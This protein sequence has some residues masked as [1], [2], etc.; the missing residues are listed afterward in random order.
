MLYRLVRNGAGEGTAV[1]AVELFGGE[2][3]DEVLEEGGLRGVLGLN[4]RWV[5][6][7]E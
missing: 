2:D 4:V 1:G 3:N 6:C 5:V 7:W